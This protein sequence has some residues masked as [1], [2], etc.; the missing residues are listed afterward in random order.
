MKYLTYGNK[1]GKTVMLI[2]GMAATALR[3]YEPL[4]GSLKDCHVVLAK[5][6]GHIPEDPS[7]LTSLSDACD[8]IER[9]IRDELGNEV[10][11]LGGFSMGATMAAEIAG[12][13]RIKL[14]KL[15][16]DAAFLVDLGP[17]LSRVY[18]G[19]FCFFIE[20]IKKGRKVPGPLLD[21]VTGKGNRSI[22]DMLYRGVRPETI[23][24]VCRYVYRYHIPEGIKDFAGDTLFLYG[25]HEPYPRRS[26]AL[27][28]SYLPGLRQKEI[29][30]M[31]H[32]Q[33][34]MSRPEDYAKLLL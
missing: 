13:G 29:Q 31:G 30:G 33:F 2:H 4:L 6:D 23:R 8:E 15:F 16:L 1:S 7:A 5:V 22:I 20:W 27:L 34:L 28:A 17:I 3:C 24:N 9:Y 12:R 11:C 14:S 10:W 21:R 19:M 26:A 18:T 25:S 32:G